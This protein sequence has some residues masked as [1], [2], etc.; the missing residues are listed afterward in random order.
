MWLTAFPPTALEDPTKQS[1]GANYARMKELLSD[2][3][4]DSLHMMFNRP[5][6]DQE[7]YSQSI[8]VVLN[9]QI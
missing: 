3:S 2:P 8:K 4:L 1:P 9:L 6:K 7:P 5:S